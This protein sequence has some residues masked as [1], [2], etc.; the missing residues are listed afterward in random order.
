MNTCETNIYLNLENIA[1]KTQIPKKLLYDYIYN[2]NMQEVFMFL[3]PGFIPFLG[4]FI[5]PLVSYFLIKRYRYKLSN[6]QLIIVFLLIWS[7]NATLIYLTFLSGYDF[8]TSL[9]VFLCN[10]KVIRAE[11]IEGINQAVRTLNHFGLEDESIVDILKVFGNIANGIFEYITLRTDIEPFSNYYSLLTIFFHC[12]SLFVIT[13]TFSFA[14]RKK[15]LIYISIVTFITFAWLLSSSMFLI[16]YVF[17]SL[18]TFLEDFYKTPSEYL[19][20][21]V[22]EF[23]DLKLCDSIN[24]CNKHQNS[25]LLS[26]IIE[27]Y[28]SENSVFNNTIVLD[29]L[30]TKL[31]DIQIFSC[32]AFTDL[33]EKANLKIVTNASFLFFIFTLCFTPTIFLFFPLLTPINIEVGAFSS[34]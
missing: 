23:S 28:G 34:V 31:D 27:N 18:N 13:T 14:F 4:L 9:K 29:D 26:N 6:L 11:Y 32:S 2:Y 30:K 3:I 12:L 8:I 19:G 24:Y 20:K 21:N 17:S 25:N 7:L 33:A 22:C 16:S 5:I 15:S 1:F 10:I